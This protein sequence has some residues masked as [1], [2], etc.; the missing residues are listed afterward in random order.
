MWQVLETVDGPIKMLNAFYDDRQMYKQRNESF[1][2]ILSYH[3]SPQP[4]TKLFCQFWFDNYSNPFVAEV[5]DFKSLWNSRWN[6]NKKGFTPTLILCPNP[7]ASEDLIPTSVSVV[8]KPC[9]EASNEFKV[10][11][12]LPASKLKKPIAACM[13]LM[14]YKNDDRSAILMEWFETMFALGIN[15]I[16]VHAFNIHPNTLKLL[17]F[18]NLTGKVDFVPM[19]LPNGLPSENAS[20]TQFMQNQVMAYTDCFYKNIYKFKFILPIDHDELIVPSRDVDKNLVEMLQR[21]VKTCNL[22]QKELFASYVAR[23]SL[24]L[25]NNNHQGEIQPEV[26]E[27]FH[28]LQHVYRARN[29]I[30]TFRSPKSF[31]NTEIVTSMNQHYAGDC[32]YQKCDFCPI[33]PEDAKLQHYRG[34]VPKD[35]Y[36]KREDYINNTVK[37]IALWRF[38][39]EIIANV[40]KR[41]KEFK[42]FSVNSGKWN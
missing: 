26:P 3:N 4:K 32:G 28:F 18:Y 19:T 7:F 37:D 35:V 2:K 33:D 22:V 24:F 10:I 1:V 13:K 14:E 42:T 34:E 41:E 29:F 39:D 12:N 20:H 40:N 5:L 36:T 27:S 17:K 16:I 31:L 30:E 9:D 15:Q 11:H 21:V 6:I 23:H 25:L 38:K 8:Q